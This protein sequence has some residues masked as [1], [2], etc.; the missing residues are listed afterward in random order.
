MLAYNPDSVA[1]GLFCDPVL[2]GC[3]RNPVGVNG[4]YLRSCHPGGMQDGS[5]WSFRGSREN[6]HRLT[7]A[8]AG[9]IPEGCQTHQTSVSLRVKR[10]GQVQKLI[11]I[12]AIAGGLSGIPAGRTVP[13]PQ[14]SGGRSGEK[15]ER[16][17]ATFCQPFG[18]RTEVKNDTDFTSV[19][20]FRSP[21]RFS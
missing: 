3:C 13:L 8:E 5:R 9:C 10:C 6:D 18:L 15:T 21:K 12:T 1:V 4:T 14:V 19:S 16:P 11:R 2:I 17:P 7:G 20:S